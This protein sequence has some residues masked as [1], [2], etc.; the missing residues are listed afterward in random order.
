MGSKE[1]SIQQDEDVIYS[2]SFLN[3]QE[4]DLF[5]RRIGKIEGLENC[6]HLKKLGLRK[7]LI[8]KIENI[9]H[10]TKLEDLELYDNQ[11]TII[12]GLDTLK[13]LKILD[14]SFN[15][16]KK[17]QGIDKLTNIEKLFLLSNRFK[18]V[19]Q[20]KFNLSLLD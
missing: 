16:L 13:A 19:I 2:L 4:I 10:L 3:I 20:K 18:K 6:K 7:N 11:L 9:N 17:I 14:L 1:C 5:D 8:R 12:E 15:N